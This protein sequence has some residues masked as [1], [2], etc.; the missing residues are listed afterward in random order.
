[1]KFAVLVTKPSPGF[2]HGA[3]TTDGRYIVAL[4][5]RSPV[6]HGAESVFRRF[7]LQKILLADPEEFQLARGQSRQRTARYIWLLR[8]TRCYYA[9]SHSKQSEKKAASLH[10][11]HS[12]TILPRI[13]L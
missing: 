6:E 11:G 3:S 10:M 1:M 12:T 9:N 8:D 13:S 2:Q 7:N 5:T 4:R